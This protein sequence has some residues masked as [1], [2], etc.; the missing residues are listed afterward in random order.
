MI[1]QRDN[2]RAFGLS[3]GVHLLCVLLISAGVWWTRKE[4]PISVAG[5][6]VEATLVSAPPSAASAPPRPARP[7]PPAAPPPQPKPTP[8]PQ[9]AETPP[10]PKPQAPPPQ[11]DTRDAEAAARL[12]IQQAEEKAR[13]EQRERRRQEQVLLEEQRR[14]EEVERRE[15]LR[16]QQEEREKQLAE[17]RRQREAAERQR[18]LEAERLQQIADARRQAADAAQPREAPPG[19][20]LGNNGVDNS[21][22]GRYQLAIQQAVTQ[23]WLRPESTRPGIRCALRI[24]QIPGGEVIQASVSTPCNADDLTRRSIEAAV[25]KAQ[26]LPYSGYESVFRR[27]ILFTFRYDGE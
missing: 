14:Q 5:S 13:E 11:P 25:L 22:L 3:L 20:Q 6:V 19:Q 23:N 8:A 10:Q 24:V 15:R 27:E 12:A 2:L 4:A 26:P 16:K 17:I 7:D 9:Q 1:S 18:K 21:L